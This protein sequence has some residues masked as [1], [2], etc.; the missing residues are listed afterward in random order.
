MPIKRRD[1]RGVELGSR[2][3]E[4]TILSRKM[5]RP[6]FGLDGKINTQLSVS[7]GDHESIKTWAR[8]ESTSGLKLFQGVGSDPISITHR[9]YVAFDPRINDTQTIE[10][11]NRLFDIINIENMDERDEILRINTVLRGDKYAPAARG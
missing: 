3:T 2:D 8:V 4:I 1:R 6:S 10:L 9:F 5:T 11:K 7:L